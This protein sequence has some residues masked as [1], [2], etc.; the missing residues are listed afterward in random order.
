[1]PSDASIS[2]DRHSD[3][4]DAKPDVGDPLAAGQPSQGHRRAGSG[5]TTPAIS[6]G[7][8]LTVDAS[9]VDASRDER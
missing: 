7:A 1:M 3:R 4:P 5:G 8:R 9:I 2:Q 6:A